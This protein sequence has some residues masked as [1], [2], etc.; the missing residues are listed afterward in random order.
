MEE[1]GEGEILV[2]DAKG[3]A[4]SCPNRYSGID[5]GTKGHGA[6]SHTRYAEAL[7]SWQTPTLIN[8]TNQ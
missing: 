5:P 2:W 1:K 4:S 6:F 8:Y 3:G 7:S